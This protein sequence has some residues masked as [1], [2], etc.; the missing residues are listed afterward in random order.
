MQEVKEKPPQQASSKDITASGKKSPRDNTSI[1]SLTL[2]FVVFVA[3]PYEL[4]V[5]GFSL[6][7]DFALTVLAAGV[8]TDIFTT[9]AG[10]NRG[11]G[12]YNII[13]NATK[14]KVKN[15]SFLVGVA[16]FAAIRGFL[17][18]YFWHNEFILLLVAVISL[19]GPLWNSVMLSIPDAKPSAQLTQTSTESVQRIQ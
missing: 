3:L 19:V 6:I 10:F 15:D 7:N 4:Y 1:V 2:T 5:M 13:Y 9:K 11:F 18:Y 14:K 17:I 12:D 16:V 8:L